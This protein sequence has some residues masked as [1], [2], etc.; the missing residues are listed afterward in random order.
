[1]WLS[2]EEYRTEKRRVCDIHKRE[3]GNMNERS[4]SRILY[5]DVLNIA[6]CIAVI[7]LH[8]NGIVHSFTN[9]LAWRESLIAECAFYW[10]VPIFLMLSG[11]NLLN[12]R[13]KYSTKVFF[14]KRIIRTVIPWLFWSVVMLV[15]CTYCISLGIIFLLKKIPLI[16]KYICG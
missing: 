14:K 9:T 4:Q 15:P 8:H 3:K 13:E 6:A 5:F 16:G 12:Y 11:A 7:F 1:M 2:L 10:A